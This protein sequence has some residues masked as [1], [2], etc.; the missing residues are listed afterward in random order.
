MTDTAFFIA[1]LISGGVIVWLLMR[2][3]ISKETAAAAAERLNELSAVRGASR[4]RRRGL[5]N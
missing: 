5:R 4:P 2:A 1:G 3:K